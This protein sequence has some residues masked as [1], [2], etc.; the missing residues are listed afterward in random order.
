MQNGRKISEDEEFHRHLIEHRRIPTILSFI[1]TPARITDEEVL[2]FVCASSSHKCTYIKGA[3]IKKILIINKVMQKLDLGIGTIQNT[4]SGETNIDRIQNNAPISIVNKNKKEEKYF[5]NFFPWVRI[6]IKNRKLLASIKKTVANT[7]IVKE[8]NIARPTTVISTI[9]KF[10]KI[11]IVTQVHNNITTENLPLC[12]AIPSLGI[13][14]F[15]IMNNESTY[16]N[17][18]T[19]T[20]STCIFKSGKNSICNIISSHV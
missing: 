5:S 11:K 13:Y 19:S 20:R 17:L 2:A 4:Y 15:F 7:V 3:L 8:A 12:K 9:L 14:L 10:G 1:T 18:N 6:I 16:K